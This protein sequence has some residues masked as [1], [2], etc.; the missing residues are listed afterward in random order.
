LRAGSR[1]IGYC[2][3]GINV[4]LKE[5]KLKGEAL[6]VQQQM[7]R[8]QNFNEYQLERPHARDAKPRRGESGR[9]RSYRQTL[10]VVCA[11]LLIR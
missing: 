8:R 11:H 9:H 7:Q 5:K 4:M 2:G 3:T 6:F 10:S 1:A